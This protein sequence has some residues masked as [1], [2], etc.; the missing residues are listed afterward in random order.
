MDDEPESAV[1]EVRAEP[2]V[3]VASQWQD[4]DFQ[5][6]IKMMSEGEVVYFDGEENPAADIKT[7]VELAKRKELIIERDREGRRMLMKKASIVNH[8]PS[9]FC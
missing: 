4:R 2:E 3:L 1:N 6:I 9:L 8:P 7:L 5:R